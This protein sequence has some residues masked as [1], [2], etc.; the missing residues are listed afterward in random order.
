MVIKV[1]VNNGKLWQESLWTNKLKLANN[2]SGPLEQLGLVTELKI[3]VGSQT[4]AIDFSTLF[5]FKQLF[6]DNN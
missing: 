1:I 3:F 4:S 6:G 2:T 5:H